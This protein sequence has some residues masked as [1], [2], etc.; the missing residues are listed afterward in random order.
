MSL[1]NR[2]SEA[3]VGSTLTIELI[4]E[5]QPKTVTAQV[6]E[7]PAEFAAR[8]NRNQNNPNLPGQPDTSEGLAGVE[9]QEL[10]PQLRQEANVPPT[11]NG[12]IVTQV[13][14]G[15]AAAQQ[16]QP[17]DVIEEINRQPVTNVQQF[18]QIT[19]KLSQDRPI[20]LGI[21]RERQRSF[22]IIQPTG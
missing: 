20:V 22:V 13:D 8:M 5:G 11:V 17:G 4:R 1:S 14:P 10:T 19:S 18:N 6:V 7:Q 12:V 16:V 21:S 3:D 9:V 15:S 2:I